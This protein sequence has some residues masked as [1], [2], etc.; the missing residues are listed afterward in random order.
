MIFTPLADSMPFLRLITLH[1]ITT[2]DI[3]A[4]YFHYGADSFLA[5]DMPR[6][7]LRRQITAIS[8]IAAA[9]SFDCR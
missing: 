2:Y 7:L 8:M 1:F 4:E 6:R 3:A 9:A 5:F